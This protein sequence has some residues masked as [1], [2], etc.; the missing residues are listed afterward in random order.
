MQKTMDELQKYITSQQIND[1]LN[2]W[3]KPSIASV[4]NLSIN[5]LVLVY[6]EGN[7]G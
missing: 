6:Q 2:T 1:V 4:H 5:S 3:N 7:S